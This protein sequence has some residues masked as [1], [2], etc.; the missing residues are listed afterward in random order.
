VKR[1]KGGC[2]NNSNWN[3]S[4]DLASLDFIQKILL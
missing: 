1:V 3:S 4:W 2:Q